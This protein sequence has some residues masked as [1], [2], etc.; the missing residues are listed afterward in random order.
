MQRILFIATL[1]AVAVALGFAEGASSQTGIE[2]E[3][4][5]QFPYHE[6]V[7][8]NGLVPIVYG[9]ATD[10]L[11]GLRQAGSTWGAGTSRASS[12]ASLLIPS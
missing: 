3:G 9:L 10:P 2:L 12:T 7:D 4:D 8:A 1:A 11:L 6:G 5:Y